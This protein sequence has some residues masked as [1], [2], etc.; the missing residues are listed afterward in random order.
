VA[1]VRLAD[2]LV[3]FFQ[4]L[5]KAT[6]VADQFFDLPPSS[7]QRYSVVHATDHYASGQ[8]L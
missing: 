3:D 7:K 1:G 4:Q 2:A 8:E 6:V 5:K